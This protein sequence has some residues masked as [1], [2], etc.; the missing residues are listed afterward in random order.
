DWVGSSRSC[1]APEQG[2]SQILAESSEDG[3]GTEGHFASR[4]VA[5][6]DAS[7]PRWAHTHADQR[8]NATAVAPAGP[9]AFVAFARRLRRTRSPSTRRAA[10][11]PGAEAP[12]PAPR[13]AAHT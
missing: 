9:E 5:N 7:A 3:R 1:P 8:G 10:A 6:Q 12:S 4:R 11:V 2:T 13:S